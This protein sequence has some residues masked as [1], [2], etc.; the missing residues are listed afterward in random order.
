MIDLT[1]YKLVYE[2]TSMP[3]ILFAGMTS[4]KDPYYFDKLEIPAQ[5][6]PLPIECRFLLFGPEGELIEMAHR[7]EFAGSITSIINAIPLKMINTLIAKQ[8]G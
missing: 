7:T 5:L 6:K 4:A 1:Q 2:V 3:H 8:T